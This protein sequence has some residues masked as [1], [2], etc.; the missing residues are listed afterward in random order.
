METPIHS[1]PYV[2][3]RCDRDK[4]DEML[5]RLSELHSGDVAT[6]LQTRAGL[7]QL[8]LGDIADMLERA[9]EAGRR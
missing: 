2:R 8:G 9:G 1:G 7:E 3:H 6:G 4:W 5:D